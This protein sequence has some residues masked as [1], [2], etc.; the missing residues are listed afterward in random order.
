MLGACNKW[1]EK[2]TQGIRNPNCCGSMVCGN[3]PSNHDPYFVG[4]EGMCRDEGK[5]QK[6]K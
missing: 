4:Q 5:R 6:H 1:G 2:C 3:D